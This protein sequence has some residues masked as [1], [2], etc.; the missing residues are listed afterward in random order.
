MYELRE[1]ALLKDLFVWAYERSAHHYAEVRQQ[2]GSPDPFRVAHRDAM[3][4]LVGEIV[5]AGA[6]PSEVPGRV[7]AWAEA[8]VA[9]PDRERFRDMVELALLNL[10]E[11]N[12]A[13]FRLR[14]SEFDAWRARGRGDS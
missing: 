13:R 14:P 3:V 5:R 4:H 2:L 1:P 10:N 7:R 6:E 8:N 12:F 11:S 9:A